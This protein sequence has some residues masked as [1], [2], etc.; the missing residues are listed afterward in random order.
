MFD[1][2]RIEVWI[3]KKDKLPYQ[4]SLAMNF[5]TA[6]GGPVQG[7]MVLTSNMKNYNQPFDIV[8]PAQSTNVF[9]FFGSMFSGGMESMPMPMPESGDIR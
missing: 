6:A 5:R 9:D 1:F 3:G 2:E 4:W 8:P 7:K